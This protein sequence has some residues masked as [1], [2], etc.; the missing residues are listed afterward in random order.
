MGRLFLVVVMSSFWPC[1]L[2]QKRGKFSPRPD[3]IPPYL[4][5]GEDSMY[6]TLYLCF[7]SLYYYRKKSPIPNIMSLKVGYCFQ[8]QSFFVYYFFVFFFL[9]MFCQRSYFYKM[10]NYCYIIFTFFAFVPFL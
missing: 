6:L 10:N 1:C 2:P 3:E 7:V 9:L 4:P 5:G 8:C